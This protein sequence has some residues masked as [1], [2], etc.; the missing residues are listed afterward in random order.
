MMIET[1]L[2]HDS[3]SLTPSKL[4][5][6]SGLHLTANELIS[7]TETMPVESN[8]Y[9]MDPDSPI[10]SNSETRVLSASQHSSLLNGHIL[11][12]LSHQQGKSRL[13][14]YHSKQEYDF[15]SVSI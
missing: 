7:K 11:P 3:L 8:G 15:I 9:K 12:K 6:Q 1:P 4:P 13:Y 10:S 2:V 5:R 14:Y